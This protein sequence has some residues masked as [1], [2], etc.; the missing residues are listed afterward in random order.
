MPFGLQSDIPDRA[1]PDALR[2]LLVEQTTALETLLHYAHDIMDTLRSDGNLSPQERAT[3]IDA[4][5]HEVAE[6][7][8]TLEDRNRQIQAQI[9]AFEQLLRRQGNSI[10]GHTVE[11]VKEVMERNLAVARHHLNAIIRT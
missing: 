10:L 11:R 8:N 5:A 9:E 6:R 4:L 3:Q 2:I 1:I 7:W